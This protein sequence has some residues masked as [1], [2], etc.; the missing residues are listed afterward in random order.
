MKFPKEIRTY[1]PYCNTHTV[2]KVIIVKKHERGA[3]SAGQRRFERTI[4][5]YGGFPKPKAKVIKQTKR[6]DIRLKCTQCGKIHTK[7]KTFRAKKLELVAK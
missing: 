4:K 6:W 5:G 7:T 3:L 1:C 2:H